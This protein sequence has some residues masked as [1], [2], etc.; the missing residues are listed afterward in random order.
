MSSL[1]NLKGYDPNHQWA[2]IARFY[3]QQAGEPD[4]E[5]FARQIYQES[6]FNP[7]AR[8]R[9]DARG[10]A[11]FMPGT[12]KRYN[13]DVSNPHQSLVAALQYRSDIR[14]YLQRHGIEPSESNILASYN[15]GEGNVRKYKGLPPF[16]E[17]R[18]YVNRILNVRPDSYVPPRTT[19]PQVPRQI[20]W[21][22]KPISDTE[23]YTTT[24]RDYTT[25]LSLKPQT[26]QQ[27]AP[28]SFRDWVT[29]QRN[30]ILGAL[31]GGQAD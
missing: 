1:D 3:A 9:A 17:T 16:K 20:P 8:S 26:Q 28:S 31:Y 19:T 25:G 24:P 23:R 6:Q 5:V 7:N 11:Q 12:A 14:K 29:Q 18:T 15:A 10:L 22:Y 27:A 30:A 13:L 2:R 21:Q 4:P